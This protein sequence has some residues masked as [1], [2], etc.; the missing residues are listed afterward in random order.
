MPSVS[1]KLFQAR[2]LCLP[3]IGGGTVPDD[4]NDE[5]VTHSY[6]YL[7]FFLALGAC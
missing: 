2:F 5:S 7:L 3:P 6:T 4:R 1:P